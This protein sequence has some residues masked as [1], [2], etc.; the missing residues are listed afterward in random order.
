MG[1]FLNHNSFLLST[2]SLWGLLGWALLR[3]G[4]SWPRLALLG[5]LTIVITAVFAFLRPKDPVSPT[6]GEVHSRIGAGIPVLV[7]IKS[8]N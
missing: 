6:S 8:P 5:L 7:E 2:L 4:F 3:Q 1:E